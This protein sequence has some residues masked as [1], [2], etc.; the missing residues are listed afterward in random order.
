MIK[1][2]TDRVLLSVFKEGEYGIGGQVKQVGSL[3]VVEDEELKKEE[4][5]K[6]CLVESFGPEC[7]TVTVG[8]KV[9]I[10]KHSGLQL[11]DIEMDY[12][13]L[14]ESEILAFIN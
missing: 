5:F 1:P 3:Y 12:I 7:K 4:S 6:K 11:K 9:L 14:R 10:S 8:D 2:T 13:I